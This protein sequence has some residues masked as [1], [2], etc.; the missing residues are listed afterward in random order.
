MKNYCLKKIITVLSCA[1]LSALFIVILFFCAPKI[2]AVP[3]TS[4]KIV[5]F[6]YADGMPSEDAY[7]VG[8]DFTA[9]RISDLGSLGKLTKVNYVAN[10]FVKPGRITHDMQIVDLTKPFEFA[11]KGTL[12]FA[13]MNLD[14]WAEDFDAQ[15]EKLNEYKIGD[16]WRFT[17][18]VP[19]IYSASNVYVNAN[20]VDRHGEIENYDFIEFTT[21]YDKTTAAYSAET[22]RT[23]IDLNFYT[24]RE[25]LANSFSSTQFITVH[26]QSSGSAYSGI[27]EC[28]LV[29]T[30][31]AVKSM[32]EN[33]QTLLIT[34]AVL[35]AV[36]LAVFAVLAALKRTKEFI[37]DIMLILGIAA[38]LFSRFLLGGLTT[39]PLLWAA[40]SLASSFVVLCGALLSTGVNFKKVPTKFIFPALAAVGALFAFI[41]PYIPFGAA[42]AIHIVCLA[43][44]GVCSAALLGFI[45]LETLCKNS[46]NS[47]LKLSC[48]AIIAVSLCASLFMPQIF[49]AQINP[50][51][52]LYVV[53][54]LTTFVSVFMIF[55][56]TEK[57]NEYLTANLHLE[58]ERQVKDIKAVITE[59]DRLLQFV[60]HDM[61][62]PLMSSVT[63]LDA[64]IEREKDAEQIKALKIIKQN[65][66]RIVSNL[67][68][69]GAYA[70]FNYIAEPS[71]TVDLGELCAVLYKYHEL[72]CNA[73]GIVL[74]NEADKRYP[75]FVK[76]QGLEN[77]ISNIIM[78]A[79]EHAHCKTISI[80][81][82]S[83]K[84]KITLCVADDGTGIDSALDVFKPY[85]SENDTETGGVGLYI[86]KNIIESMNGKLTYESTRDGTT[87][88]ISLLKA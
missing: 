68:E 20:L 79:V 5:E 14:P 49:P 35:A 44:K 32:P 19:N 53:T 24:R 83:D 33:S 7:T 43:I 80:Y 21:S 78:N 11:E 55:K 45:C 30:E 48:T 71:Q 85:V 38:L 18:S 9:V 22:E 3:E 60:S 15:A 27:A 40:I 4:G 66:S 28:P 62:K 88:Y 42:S 13:I 41:C 56:E 26:Y 1:A 36:V 73:N 57:A 34:F 10:E 8:T 81:V 69:I 47:I 6:K 29:G 46:G 17:L 59:R 12:I 77:V 39:T 87:F 54:V 67:S 64:A 16:Y 65:D 72:D 37:P 50:L 51:F 86:C 25:A 75:V 52:W 70:K 74:K 82:K 76:K 58:V 23:V 61:K 63:L 31:D 2:S 84:S